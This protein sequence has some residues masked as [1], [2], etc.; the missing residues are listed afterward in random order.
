MSDLGD[1]NAYPSEASG[2][3]P[4]GGGGRK[5]PIGI[6]LNPYKELTQFLS[7]ITRILMKK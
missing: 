3:C 7:G 4:T 6:C 2:K 5:F 1:C